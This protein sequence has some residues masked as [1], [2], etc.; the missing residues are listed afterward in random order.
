MPTGN[1]AENLVICRDGT[2]NEISENVSNVLKLY[3]C[4]R[5]TDTTQPRQLVPCE[6]K[7]GTVTPPVNT[8]LAR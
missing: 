6:P 4:L 8:P 5:K 7:A 3:R 2:G 1:R